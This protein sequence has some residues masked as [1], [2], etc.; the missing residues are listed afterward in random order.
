ME[1]IDIERVREIIKNDI[2]PLRCC[3]VNG[4]VFV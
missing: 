1:L 2:T 4:F 3:Q